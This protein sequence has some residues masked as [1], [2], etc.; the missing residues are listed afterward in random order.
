MGHASV[1]EGMRKATG[2]ETIAFGKSTHHAMRVAI[3][4]RTDPVALRLSGTATALMKGAGDLRTM[5]TLID[6]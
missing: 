4:L 5:L 1:E 3:D 6:S 2:Q